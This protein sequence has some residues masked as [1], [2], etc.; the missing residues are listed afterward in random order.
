M[1]YIENILNYEDY[2][3]L[4]ESVGWNNFS[5][6][7]AMT[8]LQ[9]SVH[10]ISV[11]E[12]NE[13]IAMGRLIGDGLYYIIA[14]IVVNPSYQGMKIGTNIIDL[15]LSHIE[16]NTPV[17]GRVSVQ[18]ISEKGKEGFYEKIGFKRIPNENCG[19]GMRKIIRK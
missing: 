6:E 8:A 2:Y 13:T 17:G 3:S 9:N 12:N 4:R 1:Q 16:K 14:D 5:K 11:L 19:S 15:L 10:I 7:Q 18:L